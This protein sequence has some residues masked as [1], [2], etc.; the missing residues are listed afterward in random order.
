MTTKPKVKTSTASSVVKFEDK[1]GGHLTENIMHF[2]R[3]LRRAGFPVGPGQVLD[4]L[5]AVIAIGLSSRGDFYWT[6]HAVLVKHHSQ[7]EMFDQAFYI[8]WQNPKILEKMM[9]LVLPD[10]TRLNSEPLNTVDISKRLAEAL[11]PGQNNQS[12]SLKDEETETDASLT[13]SAFEAFEEKDFEKMSA[14]EISRAVMA[15]HRM[16]LPLNEV[17]TRRFKTS[18]SGVRIDMRSTL[19]ASLRSGTDFIPLMKKKRSTRRPPLVI[20]CDISGSMECYSRM[21][22]HFMYTVT[23]DRDRV[24]TFIFG[25]RLTNI[26]RY[27]RYR[28]VD[29]S[30]EKVGK[31]ATDWFGGTR[32]GHSLADFNKFWSRRVLSQGAVVILISDGLD[33]DEGDGLRREMHRLNLSCRRLIWLNPLLRYEGFEPKSVGIK[34]MLP[35][36][37]EFRTIHNLKSI[38]DL[39]HMFENEYNNSENFIVK[40]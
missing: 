38:N 27:L 20:L 31:I 28:D 25:T 36:V 1:I 2:V 16:K 14:D 5:K 34:A 24:H 15:V 9:Q 21:L 10:M 11:F 30:L 6:L 7:R 23:N 8:F 32:I 22:L 13:W 18:N 33:R 12:Q 29:S 26:T 17:P 37:D 4:T 35:Y 19:R 39:V 40:Q 3:V